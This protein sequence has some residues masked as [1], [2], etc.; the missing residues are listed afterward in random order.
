MIKHLPVPAFITEKTDYNLIEEAEKHLTQLKKQMVAQSFLD[1]FTAFP[2]IKAFSLSI[3]STDGMENYLG[4]DENTLVFTQHYAV[5]DENEVRDALFNYINQ[6]YNDQEEFFYK[7]TS[8]ELTPKNIEKEVAKAFG[9]KEFQS[10]QEA[11]LAFEEQIQLNENINK[12]NK[13][14]NKVKV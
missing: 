10:W 6:H 8:T 2:T 4:Y 13:I 7:L 12:S 1:F 11:K 9:K 5:D 14:K 3:E